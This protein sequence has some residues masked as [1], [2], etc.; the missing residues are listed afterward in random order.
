[1]D[2]D[3][4]ATAEGA[5]SAPTWAS[6]L[7]A[8]APQED[9]V[10]QS[11]P[12][13]ESQVL[14]NAGG[15]VYKI[16]DFARLRRFI[17]LGSEANNYY[18]KRDELELQNAE[19]VL[20]LLAEGQGDRVVAEVKAISLEGRAPRQTSAIAGH[21]RVG[22][23]CSNGALPGGIGLPALASARDGADPCD[24]LIDCPIVPYKANKGSAERCSRVSVHVDPLFVTADLRP[25]ARPHRVGTAP[26]QHEPFPVTTLTP[27]ADPQAC[28]T[29][30][31]DRAAASD[32]RTHQPQRTGTERQRPSHSDSPP[33]HVAQHPAHPAPARTRKVLCHARSPPRSECAVCTKPNA[34]PRRHR[35][36]PR[37]DPAPPRLAP[38]RRHT[39]RMPRDEARHRRIRNSARPP[40]YPQP[41]VPSGPAPRPGP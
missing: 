13:S 41:C 3:A 21:G 4:V 6:V 7:A 5:Q 22:G 1:M 10:P 36:P 19:C 35:R 31:G 16:D 11:A 23:R 14:N 37:P 20:R 18:V 25:R 15:F 30:L 27:R 38:S 34:N 26:H 12:L 24:M 17:I 2:V 33:V 9:A 8:V 32:A 28:P 29:T 40:P 39:G